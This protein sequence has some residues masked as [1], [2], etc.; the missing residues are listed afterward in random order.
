M[1]GQGILSVVLPW[2]PDQPPP[3]H[4][5]YFTFC[6]QGLL[7][8]AKPANACQAVEAPPANSS[9][10]IALIQRYECNFDIKVGG[11]RREPLL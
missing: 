2:Q 3:T 9:V 4:P 6:L 10:F 7:V 1:M 5:F 11:G 8:E